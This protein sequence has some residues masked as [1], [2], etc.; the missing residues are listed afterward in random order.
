MVLQGVAGWC[1]VMDPEI[2][3]EVNHTPGVS[4]VNILI[5]LI[6]YAMRRC[7]TM[8]FLPHH[9]VTRMHNHQVTNTVIKDYMTSSMLS[10]SYSSRQVAIRRS[11]SLVS[12]LPAFLNDLRL[13]NIVYSYSTI[14][15]SIIFLVRT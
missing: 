9:H 10:S 5:R 4:T 15:N 6:Q 7:L 2:G 12:T 11:L 3:G 13:I 14:I 8:C 1:G